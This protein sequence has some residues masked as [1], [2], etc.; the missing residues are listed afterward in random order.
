MCTWPPCPYSPATTSIPRC[1]LQ[2]FSVTDK[3]QKLSAL[4]SRIGA[5]RAIGEARHLI[6]A[7]ASEIRRAPQRQA[8]GRY[9][10]G[11]ARLARG[12]FKVRV[13]IG[14]GDGPRYFSCTLLSRQFV[15]DGEVGEFTRHIVV[16]VCRSRWRLRLRGGALVTQRSWRRCG[17]QRAELVE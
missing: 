16:D 11:E 10:G 5:A 14:E 17:A 4:A 6:E 8:E 7:E 2:A 13:S 3:A 9:G 15:S 12:R 1:F